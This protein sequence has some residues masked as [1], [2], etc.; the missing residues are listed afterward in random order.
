MMCVIRVQKEISVNSRAA[1]FVRLTKLCALLVGLGLCAAAHALERGSAHEK[2]VGELQSGMTEGAFTAE[3]LVRHYLGEIERIDRAGPE[4]RSVIEINPQALDMARELDEEREATGPRG[5]LHGIPV[6]LKANIDT[7][8]RMVTSAGSLALAEHIAPDD[9]FLVARLREAGAIIMGKSNLSEWANFRSSRSSSG[10]SSLGGQTKNPYDPRRNPCGSSSGSAVA[11]SANL[12]ALAV[13]TETW[14]SVICPSSINGVVGIKPTI[15][16]VSRD[17]IIPISHT[18]DTAGPMTRTVRDAALLLNVMA[19]KDAADNGIPGRPKVIPDYTENLSTD[20]LRGKRIG[21]LRNYYGAGNEPYA[22]VVF[23]AALNTLREAGAVLVDPVEID[24]GDIWEAEGEVLR[25][26]FKAGLNQYLQTSGATLDSLEEIRA[27]NE[28]N[29]D[30]V[31][32]IFAQETFVE[33]QSKGPLTDQVYLDAVANTVT[34]SRAAIDQAMAEHQVL[35]IIAP[36]NSP[37]WLTDQV[38]GDQ[39]DGVSSSS[40]AAISGYAAITVPAGLPKGLPVGLT[41][42]GG[43]YSEQVLIELAYAF[44]QASKARKAPE[45]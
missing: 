19:A 27:F 24:M 31:M 1:D 44:E 29:A 16:L 8:D 40:Y 10:W 43:A 41:F 5:P 12:T 4:L 7:G 33:S 22:D 2:S 42:F 3:D 9:A 26:E 17:G 15:G 11:V 6:L 35:A 28:A 36:S 21:V 34:S 23:E 38:H 37:A 25:Y 45:L 32:P 18:Q 20:G 39:F 14:G 13:G 30:R